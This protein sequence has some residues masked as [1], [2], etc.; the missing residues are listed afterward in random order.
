VS[1]SVNGSTISIGAP[2]YGTLSYWDNGIIQGVAPVATQIGA[3]SVVLQPIEIAGNL[4][5]SALREFISGS[6]SSSSNS[7]YAVTLSVQ[8][9]LYTKNGSTLSLATSGSQSYAFTNT[10]NNSTSVLSGMKGITIPLA[11]SLTPGDYWLG[12]WSSSASA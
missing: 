3:G 9:A 6:F 5:I 2:S 1:I 10:S 7:S 4:S 11:A 12:L 8:A